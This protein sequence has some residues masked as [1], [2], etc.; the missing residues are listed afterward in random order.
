MTNYEANAEIRKAIDLLCQAIPS[1]RKNRAQCIA[2]AVNC[3]MQTVESQPHLM[4]EF[5]DT[6]ERLN[7]MA[8]R[9]SA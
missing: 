4:T 7:L 8:I 9:Q 5:D 6:L 2:M 1:R 3:L